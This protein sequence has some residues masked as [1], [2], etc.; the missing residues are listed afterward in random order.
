MSARERDAVERIELR[1][2]PL[3]AAID[4]RASRT[5]TALEDGD[6]TLAHRHF[7]PVDDGE[8]LLME[9]RMTRRRSRATRTGL[10]GCR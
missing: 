10:T 1:S 5:E 9:L 3:Q 7:V 8:R 6:R 2:A 4:G